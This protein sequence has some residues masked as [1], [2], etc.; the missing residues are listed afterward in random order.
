[1]YKISN[2]TDRISY[3]RIVIEQPNRHRSTFADGN[4]ANTFSEVICSRHLSYNNSNEYTYK[5]LLTK[6]IFGANQ[7][8]RT[9]FVSA[10]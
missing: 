5:H 10:D 6:I 3:L 4:V 8:T 1:M 2:V 9:A 7:G